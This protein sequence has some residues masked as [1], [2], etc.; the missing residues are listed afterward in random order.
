VAAVQENCHPEAERNSLLHVLHAS[1][2]FLLNAPPDKALSSN[3]RRH[4]DRGI[5]VHQ[6]N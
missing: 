1:E 2:G 5:L 6:L 3:R 4:G